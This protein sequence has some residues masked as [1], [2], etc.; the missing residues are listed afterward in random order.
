M[1]LSPQSCRRLFASAS[2]TLALGACSHGAFNPAGPELSTQLFPGERGPSNRGGVAVAPKVTADFQGPPSSN[3][4]WSSLIWQFDDDP[5][6]RP[7]FPHPLAMKAGAQGLGIGY[8][9]EPVVKPREY[10]FPYAEDLLLSVVGLNAADTRVASWSDWAVTASWGGVPGAPSSPSMRVTFGH[11]LPFVYARIRGGKALVQLAGGQGKDAPTIWSEHGGVLGLTWHGHPYGLFAPTGATWTR[12]PAGLESDL[13]GKDYYSVAVLP[14]DSPETL[15]LFRTHAYAFVTGTQVRWKVDAASATLTSH[16]AV[17]TTLVEAGDGHV[18][19]PILAL[20]PHQW[21][22]SRAP[23]LAKGSYASPRG[24]MRLLAASAFD[25]VRPVHGVLPVLPDLEQDQRDNVRG[26]LHTAA[27]AGDLFP[28]GLD[29]AKDTYWAGKSLGRVSNLAW[30]ASQLGDAPAT[31]SLTEALER[32]LSDWFDGQPPNR[33]YYDATWHSLIGFPAGYQSNTELNDHHFHYGYFVWAAAT[34]AALDPEF[35]ALSRWGAM[36]D[37]LVRDVANPEISDVRFPRLRYFDPYAG[38]S[39]ANGPAAFDEGNNE[40]SSSEDMNFAAAVALWGL[41]TGDS[42][43]QDLG[44]FLYETTASAID[45]AWLDADHDVFPPSY[46]H[47]VAGIVWGDGA[48]FTTWW[49]P[50]PVYVHGINMVPFTGA[51]LYLGRR[52]DQVSARYEALLEDNHGA[53]HQWRDVLWMDLALADA[54]KAQALLDDDHYFTPEFGNS[55]AAV[56]YWIANLRALGHVEPSVLAD[57]GSYAVF[58][59]GDSRTYAAYNP[60]EA[61]LRVHFT[62]GATLDVGAR[63]LA[64]ATGARPVASTVGA[65]P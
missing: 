43:T 31:K 53:V 2:A 30:I 32:E 65:A 12:E 23:L 8:P 62:D 10:R 11:G 41:V 60:G 44:T 46:H 1:K 36:V 18:N 13:A 35:G 42:R 47:P 20:Y 61:P 17:D 14:D 28:V 39:W 54:D 63:A 3:D 37:Q 4:W 55:W 38:H 59:R 19:E 57:T 16:F 7:M 64:H 27:S 26:L 50:N 6:S 34:V 15:E 40:E 51:S 52:P 21:R 49:D 58:T 22:S 24:P 33:F 45:G 48:K 25:V 56:T 5:Y 9:S 29:G